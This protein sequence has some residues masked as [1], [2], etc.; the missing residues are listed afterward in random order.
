MTKNWTIEIKAKEKMAGYRSE[1]HM[2]VPWPILYVRETRHC[3]RVQTNYS[4]SLWFLS[5]NRS[6]LPWCICSYS[7]AWQVSRRTEYHSLYSTWRVSC[8]GI[9]SVRSNVSSN[10]FTA[11]AGVFRQRIYFPVWSCRCP[12]SPPTW[13]SSE[14]NCCCSCHVSLFLCEELH[15]MSNAAPAVVSVPDILIAFHA[16]SWGLIVSALTTK[17]RDLTQLV[18]FGEL[19]TV[20]HLRSLSAKRSSEKYRDIIAQP[21][22]PP[23]SRPLNTAAWGCGSLD[24]GGLAYS[25]LFMLSTLFCSVVIFSRVERNFG[26]DTV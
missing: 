4:G 20:C 6:S 12:A 25:T 22:D 5:S 2:A 23:Y 13:S 21:V 16:M 1:R 3:H 9:I 10:V 24:W 26:M 15:C 11:N 17:Y 8:C 14:Y 18:T 19:F 7:V